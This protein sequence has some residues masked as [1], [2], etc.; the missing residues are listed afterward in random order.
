VG[1][2]IGFQDAEVNIGIRLVK[3]GKNEGLL[4][5]D[6]EFWILNFPRLRPYGLWQAEG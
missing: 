1:V 6:F 4:I 2:E 5:L 3:Y